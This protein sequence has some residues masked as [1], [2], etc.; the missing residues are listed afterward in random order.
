MAEASPLIDAD[1]GGF[2]PDLYRGK[3]GKL[4]VLDRLPGIGGLLCYHVIKGRSACDEDSDGKDERRRSQWA[5][6]I[7]CLIS[8]ACRFGGDTPRVRSLYPELHDCRYG[9]LALEDPCGL[10]EGLRDPVQHVRYQADVLG[11]LIPV[12]KLDGLANT[13]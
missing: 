12:P 2:A 11:R 13:G 6:P 4:E 9:P 1:G 10:L 8:S 5:L 7:Q 3:K